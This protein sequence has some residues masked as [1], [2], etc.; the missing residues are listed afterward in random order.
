VKIC[1][2]TPAAPRSRHGNRTTALRWAALLRELGHRVVLAQ[3]Y[4]NQRCDVL[5]ALHA[6]RSAPSVE[7][8]R[9]RHPLAPLVVALTGTDVY[10]DL[11]GD[12][13]ARRSLELATACVVLQPL[14]LERLP[15]DARAKTR[16]IHQSASAPHA[17][18]L[19]PKAGFTAVLLAHLRDVK[20]PKLAVEAVNLLPAR[21]AV[22][23]VHLGAALDDG[24]EEWARTETGRNP[25]YE[26]RGDVPH[27]R[28][29]RVLADAQ[30]MVLTSKAEGGANVVSEALAAG[31]PVLSSRVDGSLGIL[32]DDYPGYFE[33]GRADE[34]AALL[35]RAEADAEFYGLLRTRCE[36]LRPLVSPD[37][38]RGAWAELLAGL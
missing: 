31:V 24:M 4:E 10:G 17:T 9:Q 23:V 2:V 7:R 8:F 1:I 27:W 28:A 16:V 26:W 37:R 5:V 29:M 12:Y 22:R 15:E 34:L 13:L 21:S 30:V 11:D 35:G 33:P 6:R 19:G 14:A 25:R 38:E 3:S 32:G 36:V 18:G 20:D